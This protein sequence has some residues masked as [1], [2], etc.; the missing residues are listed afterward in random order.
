MNERLK[1]DRARFQFLDKRYS[2]KQTLDLLI[3]Q[4]EWVP[5][6]MN[7]IMEMMIDSFSYFD[8]LVAFS[9]YQ[10]LSCHQY[11]WALGYVLSSMWTMAYNAR[12]GAIEIMTMKDYR[13]I[14]DENFHLANK[15]KTSDTYSYQ[16]VKT[17]DIVDIFVKY[18][19]KHVIPLEVDSDESV[20]FPSWKGTPL[21]QGE[22]SKKVNN[23]FK[24]YGYNLTITRMRSIISTHVEEKFQQNEI[25]QDEYNRFITG[26]NHNSSTHRKYY[27]KK[28]KYE[29]GHLLQE[30]YEK[31]FPQAPV[32]EDYYGSI[33]FTPTDLFAPQFQSEES[34]YLNYAADPVQTN[35]PTPIPHLLS[36]P[37]TLAPSSLPS[38]RSRD[39]ER[40]EF[41]KARSDV[42]ENKKK[43][44]WI[45]EEIDY[46]V[47]YIQNIAPQLPGAS[48]NRYAAC[49][50]FLKQS[51]PGEAIQFFH[52][53]HL[54][55]SDRLK[56]GYL[57]AMQKIEEGDCDGDSDNN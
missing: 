47:E 48:K 13:L 10:P 57:R 39:D 8:S 3:Q 23:I 31:I 21:A 36:P 2:K 52:P 54:M 12:I 50:S 34:S 38:F 14:E 9:C 46:L 5:G 44:D 11:S 35:L 7:E 19:R 40:R 45:E 15:F 6:G 24:R 28:R 27:V 43:Y 32:I 37:L 17:T 41:G 25:N 22:A 18:I 16:I 29:E 4:R 42:G 55:S 56:N 20:L 30:S 51:A 33:D 49:L 1:I 26:Q 53:H